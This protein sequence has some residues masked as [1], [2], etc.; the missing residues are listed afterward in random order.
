MIK[1]QT[2]VL[3]SFHDNYGGVPTDKIS[4][5]IVFACKKNIAMGVQ[6]I[7]VAF[8]RAIILDL[9]KKKFGLITNH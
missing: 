9:K 6:S 8:T 3:S 4:N 2:N 1:K 7:N 5:N